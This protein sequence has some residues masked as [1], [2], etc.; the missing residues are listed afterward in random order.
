MRV[1]TLLESVKLYKA[2]QSQDLHKIYGTFLSALE[3]RWVFN[4]QH[5]ILIPA[6]KEDARSIISFQPRHLRIR[7]TIFLLSGYQW[8]DTAGPVD[9]LNNRN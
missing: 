2:P 6:L 3:E 5:S 8:L 7:S 1:Q 9:Y 4:V